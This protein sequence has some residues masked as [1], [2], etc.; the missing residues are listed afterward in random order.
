MPLD[1]EAWLI[2]NVSIEKEVSLGATSGQFSWSSGCLKRLG[3]LMLTLTAY[4]KLNHRTTVDSKLATKPR[5]Y[6]DRKYL[7]LSFTI[8]QA[9]H[10]V[11]ADQKFYSHWT[12]RRFCRLLAWHLCCTRSRR[13]HPPWFCLHP[14][15]VPA[16]A[17]PVAHLQ[18]GSWRQSNRFQGTGDHFI[19]LLCSKY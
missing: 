15:L 1:T 10:Q 17:Q 18:Y 8:Y 16:A 19:S 6:C 11:R 13:H 12:T 14:R 4:L 5:D 9:K 3:K 2:I 7:P